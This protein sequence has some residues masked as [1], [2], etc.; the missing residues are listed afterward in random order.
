MR[1]LE[2]HDRLQGVVGTERGCWDLT[3]LLPQ[4]QE[5]R[6]S[7]QIVGIWMARGEAPFGKKFAFPFKDLYK[8]LELIGGN[9]LQSLF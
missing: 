3:R 9:T 8:W 7:G 6:R 4:E 5:G 2:R 1:I